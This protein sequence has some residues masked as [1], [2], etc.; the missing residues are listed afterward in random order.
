MGWFPV[1]CAKQANEGRDAE[2]GLV[3]TS[4]MQWAG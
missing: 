4:S 2:T 1:F 3:A